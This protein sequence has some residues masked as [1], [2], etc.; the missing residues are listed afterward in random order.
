MPPGATWKN[1]IIPENFT[2]HIDPIII[3]I[4]TV[5]LGWLLLTTLL[6]QT[7]AGAWQ[8]CRRLFNLG[9]TFGSA[10]NALPYDRIS[11]HPVFAVTTPWGSPYMS[12]E[13]T[14]HMDEIV[15]ERKEKTAKTM[16]DNDSKYRMVALYFMDPDD[17]CGLHAE[18]MQLDQMKKADIRI[19]ALSLGKAL[20]QAANVAGGLATGQPPSDTGDIDGLRYKVVPPK[21]Q[22]YYACR[23][24][25]CERVGLS[26]EDATMVVLGNA[27][28]TATNVRRLREVKERGPS[29]SV[30][31]MEGHLG[32]PVFS[33]PHIRRQLPWFK[34]ILSGNRFE[35]PLFF[36]Y[37]DLEE[38]FAK[39]KKPSDTAPLEPQVWNLWDVLT[40]MDK[41]GVGRNTSP[42]D[43][44]QQRLN[45]PLE[46]GLE[47]ITFVPSSK[48]VDYKEG[49]T[50]RGNSKARLPR[51]RQWMDHSPS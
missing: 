15:E 1:A 2:R 16:S 46:A 9:S 10:T 17:A 27:A 47:H 13:K 19:T 6:S 4:V 8:T 31:H 30:P 20:R 29:S 49:I 5:M 12:M 35:T 22:L 44:I 41:K 45:P 32:I 38:T 28:L 39:M 11:G 48:S 34:Q 26:R 42:L 43:A 7:E 51:Q 36:N 40:S 24:N 33:S 50:A 37:E 3:I 14:A 25:G 18:M 23:C 21:R